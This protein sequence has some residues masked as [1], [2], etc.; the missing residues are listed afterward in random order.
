MIVDGYLATARSAV[1][2][3]RSPGVAHHWTSPSALP[4]Y[5]ISGLAGHLGMAVLWVAESL[6]LP[7]PDDEPMDVVE[8]FSSRLKPGPSPDDPLHQRIRGIGEATAGDGPVQLIERVE[9]TLAG[10][11]TRLP[12]LPPDRLVL[13]NRV[14]LRLDQWLLSRTIELAVH[15]DDLAVSIDVAT[16]ELTAEAADLVITALARISMAHHGA[17]PVLRALSRHERAAVTV[18]AF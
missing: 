1:A 14:V 9:S 5:R 11:A 15:M 16:P 4:E 2:L 3:L 7:V 12:A 17:I 18:S 8:Y 13:G 10:L 6:D